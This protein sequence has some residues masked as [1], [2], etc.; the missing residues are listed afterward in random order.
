MNSHKLEKIL[1]A[2]RVSPVRIA[3]LENSEEKVCLPRCTFVFD[4][5]TFHGPRKSRPA[6]YVTFR[7]AAAKQLARENKVEIPFDGYCDRGL[8]DALD[9]AGE[10]VVY[11]AFRPWD[12]G[13]RSLVP[14]RRPLFT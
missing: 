11:P 2:A 3:W 8:V 13:A 10:K 14:G 5:K 12:L 6:S 7:L 1:K 9:A 4:N